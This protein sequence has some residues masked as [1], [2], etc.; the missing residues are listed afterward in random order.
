MLIRLNLQLNLSDSSTDHYKVDVRVPEDN[1]SEFS[2]FE[3]I[4]KSEEIQMPVLVRSK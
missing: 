4:Q 3:V 2:L 1:V